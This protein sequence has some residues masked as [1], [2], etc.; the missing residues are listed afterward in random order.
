MSR[1]NPPQHITG[2]FLLIMSA[3]TAVI[4]LTVLGACS[5]APDPPAESRR[6]RDRAAEYATIGNGYFQ[7]ANYEMALQFFELGLSENMLV[8]H[9]PG[10]VRSHNSIA[11]V[12]LAVGRFD[13]AGAE[14]N[15]ALEIARDLDAPQE[16]AKT[17]TLLGELAMRMENN[18][19]ALSELNRAREILLE[20]AF[21]VDSVLLHNLGTAH[22][23]NAE[24]SDAERYLRQALD[25]NLTDNSW[26]KTAGNYYML[27]SIASRQGDF[28]RALQLMEQ[29]LA[30]DKR[31]ENSIG[32]AADLVGVGRIYERKEQL[33]EAYPF[34][35]RALRIY[36]G[37][38]LAAPTAD[39]L[40]T[41]ERVAEELGRTE[42]AEEFGSQRMRILQQ[43]G[44]AQ[45]EME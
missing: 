42:E 26:A 12:Y 38:N 5:S 39:T 30:F 32:I 31:A 8:D 41:L 36:L 23:R 13:A 15:R 18:Q 21:E 34:Y 4:V 43:T 37:L 10:I 17:H 9:L 20:A 14:L 25:K 24:Y 27:S 44:D 16:L 6:V 33:D 40:G 29:A 35:L 22:A 2:R 28:D 19:A 1:F 7:R 11:K 3:A 45:D